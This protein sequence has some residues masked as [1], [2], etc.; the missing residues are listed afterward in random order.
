MMAIGTPGPAGLDDDPPESPEG[1]LG[2]LPREHLHE[3]E[4]LLFEPRYERI[5]EQWLAH[6]DHI[7][8]GLMLAR[9]FLPPPIHTV[10]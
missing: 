10:R 4:P 6:Q 5:G 7:P 9:Q 1:N 3:P 8:G 2:S